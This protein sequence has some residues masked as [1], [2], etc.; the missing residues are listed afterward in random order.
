MRSKRTGVFG[1]AGELV[2]DAADG[3]DQR[4]AAVQLFAQMADVHVERAIEGRRFAAVKIFHECVAGKNVARGAHQQ[5]KDVELES[6][7]IDGLT[8]GEDFARAWIEG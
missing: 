2:T 7:E 3:F 8:G 4:L 1:R 5:L 6:G